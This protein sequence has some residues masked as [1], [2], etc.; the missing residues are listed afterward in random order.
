M[1]QIAQ[2]SWLGSGEAF[3]VG[4]AAA[5]LA[6]GLS[7]WAAP[8]MVGVF[9]GFGGTRRPDRVPDEASGG[10][11]GGR[12]EVKLADMSRAGQR[13]HLRPAVGLVS[14]GHH[15]WLFHG[16]DCWCDV[17]GPL[18]GGLRVLSFALAAVVVCG[19]CRVGASRT[20]FG[21]VGW[22]GSFYVTGLVTVTRYRCIGVRPGARVDVAVDGIA[23]ADR[24]QSLGRAAPA[25]ACSW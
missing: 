22:V 1:L 24:D 16:G 18:A 15:L 23:Q 4:V 6:P 25:W 12:R 9:L 11:R 21:C 17:A 5:A 10:C 3:A 7:R 8:L 19:C 20:G 13:P 2:A 14:S